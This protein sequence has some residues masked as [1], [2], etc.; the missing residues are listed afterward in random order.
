VCLLLLVKTV[1]KKQQQVLK[2]HFSW[3]KNRAKNL[4]HARVTIFA[5]RLTSISLFGTFFPAI[6]NDR[7]LG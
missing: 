3:E 4:H 7:T 1:G 6:G 2:L 5:N